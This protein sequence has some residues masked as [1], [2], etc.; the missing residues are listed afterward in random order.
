[1][2]AG[3]HA[4]PT[5]SDVVVIGAGLAGACT[6]LALA[7]SGLRTTIIERDPAPMR[8]A[9]L[10][11]E[12]KIHLGLIYAAEAGAATALRQLAGALSFRRILRH[13]T[14]PALDR[15]PIARAFVYLVDNQSLVTPDELAEHYALLERECA[16]QFAADPKSDYL[17]RRPDRLA[18]PL[19]LDEIAAHFDPERF[20]AAFGTAEL[21]V[22]TDY[23]SQLVADTLRREPALELRCGHTLRAAE[24]RAEGFRLEGDGPEGAWSV[25]ARQVVNATWEQLYAVDEMVG[26]APPRGWLHRLK[27]RV[28]ARLPDELERAAPS[29]TMVLGAYGD[30]VVRPG[31]SSYLSWY[32]EGLQGWTEALS[33]PKD[34][35]DPCRGDTPADQAAALAEKVL[36]AID[37]WMPGV[38]RSR[39]EQVDAGAILAHGRS[40]VDDPESGLHSRMV[41]GVTSLQGWHSLNPGKL[42]TAPLHAL[43]AAEAVLAHAGLKASA[44][45]A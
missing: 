26:L 3:G 20:A 41:T 21:A 43:E 23:L 8:R 24:R 19:A 36:A 1:M 17:G 35:D 32:P 5:S 33:P 30:V 15:M 4:A 14:G 38:A 16:K 2:A 6:A 10:R 42:T 29:A 12:G 45:V 27:F 25:A 22:D 13:L 31:G 18:W 37:A 34:W 40:D 39:V 28:L 11:N 9:S 44:R 7:R